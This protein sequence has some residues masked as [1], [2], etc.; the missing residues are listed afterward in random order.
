VATEIERKFVVVDDGWKRD[1]DAGTPMRQGYLCADEA[2]SVRV[3]LTDREAKLTIKG[4]GE[5]IARS[6]YEYEIPERD[7]RE[8]LDALCVGTPIAKTRYTLERD[9]RVWEI[10]VF[11]DD[12][13]GLVL[14][15]IELDD[16]D[17]TVDVPDW[18]GREVS[19][20]ERYYNAYLTRYPF[21]EWSS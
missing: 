1:A 14:A 4:A 19:E 18:A 5:G 7:A 15:E 2:R 20:D 12:N 11:E 8:M 21:S 10:D 9:G 13:A 3:R 17:E 16:E 6:E